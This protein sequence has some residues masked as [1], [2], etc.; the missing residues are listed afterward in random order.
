MKYDQLRKS[1]QWA[2]LVVFSP[3]I[4]FH[5]LV[6]LN[7]VPAQVV[8]GGRIETRTQLYL[9]EG[10]S[11]LLNLIFLG[12]SLTA[13]GIFKISVSEKILRRSF[14]VMGIVFIV[15][16]AGNIFS[17]NNFESTFFTGVT[18]ILAFLSFVAAIKR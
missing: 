13:A 14:Y 2:L 9:F 17:L 6:V 3:S 8:W 7:I 4:L 16:T 10:I 5:V 18:F 15:N 11:L 1:A 12:I